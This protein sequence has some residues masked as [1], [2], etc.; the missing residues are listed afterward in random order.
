MCKNLKSCPFCG[1]FDVEAIWL[2]DG[3]WYVTCNK[4]GNSTSHWHS[5]EKAVSCWNA[6]VEQ[7]AS[8]ALDA[9][10]TQIKEGDFV[11]NG[12][13]CAKVVNVYSV[14]DISSEWDG[15]LF[16]DESSD[17]V[18]CPC[19]FDCKPLLIGETVYDKEGAAYVVTSYDE[20]N[21]VRLEEKESK[22][23]CYMDA[24]T[25]THKDTKDSWDK[26]RDDIDMDS[27]SYCNSR[28]LFYCNNPKEESKYKSSTAAKND[29]V[30]ARAKKLA[31]C[32]LH[33]NVSKNSGAQDD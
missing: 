11:Y 20:D 4:C 5:K 19:G 14:W 2:Y 30:V 15:E 1:S 6:R 10:G 29:D 9:Y 27:I 23:H 8:H 25:L 28:G 33:E 18:A 17:V 24:C 12:K 22:G 3:D 13:K 32:S 31:S 21:T 26:L 7:D 16:L